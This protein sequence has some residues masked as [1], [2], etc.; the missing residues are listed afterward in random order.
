MTA[1]SPHGVI[2][3]C[4]GASLPIVLRRQGTAPRSEQELCT[5]STAGCRC[6]CNN[7]LVCIRTCTHGAIGCVHNLTQHGTHAPLPLPSS[8]LI[9]Q[10]SVAFTNARA[11]AWDPYECLPVR[12]STLLLLPVTLSSLHHKRTPPIPV[13]ADAFCR[14]RHTRQTQSDTRVRHSQTQSDTRVPLRCGPTAQAPTPLL[15]PTAQP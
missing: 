1:V 6:D 4:Y 9:H 13:L 10:K 3:V 11:V 5:P 14:T 7:A 15:T 2:P 8:R 12:P